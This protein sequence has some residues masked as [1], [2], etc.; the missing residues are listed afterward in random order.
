MKY[1]KMFNESFN[2]SEIHAICKK[3]NITNYTI[4]N[5]LVDVDGDVSLSYK[6]LTELPLNF[7]KITGSFY[8]SHNKLTTLK[9]CPIYVG[10]SFLVEYNKLTSLEGGPSEVGG[11]YSC[12]DNL[13]TSLKGSPIKILNYFDCSN[14][15]LESLEGGPSEVKD[16]FY[17][18]NNKLDS[19][20]GSPKYVGKNFYCR[21]NPVYGYYETFGCNYNSYLRHTKLEELL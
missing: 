4:N 6:G 21:F 18:D 12:A 20:K 11:A 2:E 7:G 16:H 9:G 19:L 1:L 3:Y 5:G 15:I 8:C 10:D 14:N 13:L 17:C